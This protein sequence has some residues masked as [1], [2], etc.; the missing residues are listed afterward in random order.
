MH[1][2]LCAP[3]LAGLALA[4]P[5]PQ[6]IDLGGV[7]SASPP[8]FVTPPVD[9]VSDTATLLPTPT[10]VPITSDAPNTQKQ[11]NRAVKRDGN[12]ATQ[13][14]GSGPVPVPDTPSAFLSDPDLQ[15]SS[16][17]RVVTA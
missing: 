2:L 7:A 8:A 1:F 6:E 12:C 9:V 4:A 14:P 10:I 5:R 11:S 3:V 13:P 17:V 15:V 16:F